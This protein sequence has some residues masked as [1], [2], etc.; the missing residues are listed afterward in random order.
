[1]IT[2][3]GNQIAYADLRERSRH[4]RV[5]ESLDKAKNREIQRHNV[6]TEIA[7][8]RSLDIQA[9]YNAGRINL[10]KAK[11]NLEEYKINNAISRDR[12]ALQ[13]QSAEQSRRWYQDAA[14]LE[15]KKGEVALKAAEGLRQTAKDVLGF[16]NPFYG[17][18]N[19]IRGG[20]RNGQK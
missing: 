14:A 16:V 15:L 12:A 11:L 5:Q 6:N 8:T 4:N 19:N 10:D 2:L 17:L 1:M 9:A 3:T 20:K 18:T 7:N 13:L